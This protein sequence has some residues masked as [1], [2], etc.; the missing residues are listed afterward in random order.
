MS[1]LSTDSVH[2]DINIFDQVLG[3]LSRHIDAKPHYIIGI[4]LWA[5]HT[6]I[7]NRY[8]KSPRLAIISPVPN[9]GKSTVLNIL[10]SMVWNPEKLV[11]PTTASK[12]R[13]ASD[14]TLLLDEVDNLSI[15]RSMKAILNNGHEIGGSVPRTDRDGQIIKRLVYGPL[16][17]ASI[18][19]LPVTLMSRSIVIPM[20]RSN[21]QKEIFNPRDAFYSEEIARWAERLRKGLISLPLGRL[22]G[23]STAVTKR[24]SPTNTTIG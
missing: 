7:Y 3:C 14:R 12:F 13:L 17:L 19:R 11:D 24:P 8:D 6:H 5:L 22:A 20:H 4:S 10:N 16:A 21:A 2:R 1:T 9:C 23:R 15:T 18:G